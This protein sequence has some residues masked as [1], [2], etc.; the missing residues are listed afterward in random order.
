MSSKSPILS[1]VSSNSL[2]MILNQF[3]QTITPLPISYY[4]TALLQDFQIKL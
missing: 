1:I 4:L 3:D 2:L